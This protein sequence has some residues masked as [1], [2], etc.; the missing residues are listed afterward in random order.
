MAEFKEVIRQK[1][2]MCKFYK[3]CVRADHPLCGLSPSNNGKR[4]TCHDFSQAYP[5]KTDEIVMN[6]A[7][8]HPVKTNLD[9]LMEIFPTLDRRSIEECNCF[10]F[11]CPPP[12]NKCDG[13]AGFNYWNKEY[14]GE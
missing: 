6:W 11:K 2:R 9:K 7:K 8:E 1:R 10:G 3:G 14:K 4:L 12:P 5:E 13:C